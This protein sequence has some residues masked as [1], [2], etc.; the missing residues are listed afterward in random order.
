MSKTKLVVNSCSLF[1]VHLAVLITTVFIGLFN[2]IAFSQPPTTNIT[3]TQAT[4][5]LKTNRDRLLDSY[6]LQTNKPNRQQAWTDMTPSQKGV[7]LTITDLLG[8]RTLMHPNNNFSPAVLTPGM[9]DYTNGCFDMNEE[10]RDLEAQGAY[11][12]T[13]AGGY[14]LINGNW[15]AVPEPSSP[16][17]LVDVETCISKGRCFRSQLPRTDFDMALNHV[18]T[19]YAVNGSHFGDC[20][21]GE[22]NRVFFS[23]DDELIYAVRNIDFSA[24]I[25]WWRSEDVF[26]PHSPFTQSRETIGGRP[27]GQIHEWAWDYQAITMSRPGVYGVYNP[28]LVEM[29]IDYN[30]IHDSNPECSYGGV[31]GRYKYQN[32]WYGQG[33]GGSAEFGYSPY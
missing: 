2:I 27:K 21:G 20:G 9:D 8:R 18:V 26:G 29:D 12:A 6:A 15:V 30:S 17:E 14:A 33:L 4:A 25:G 10:Y 1:R 23:A 13:A 31:Y 11:I 24:P 28:H 22:Y 16:C 32:F 5:S 19:L 3:W 7:F